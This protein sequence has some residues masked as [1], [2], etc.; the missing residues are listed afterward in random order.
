MLENKDDFSRLCQQSNGSKGSKEQQGF[1]DIIKE[2]LA[3]RGHR[4][5]SP[6]AI[7]ELR[8]AFLALLEQKDHLATGQSSGSGR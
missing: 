2:V 4:D 8:E 7:E 5:P 6:S 3:K 1:D